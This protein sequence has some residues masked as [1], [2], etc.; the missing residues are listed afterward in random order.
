MNVMSVGVLENAVTAKVQKLK[1]AWKTSRGTTHRPWQ[2]R[3]VHYLLDCLYSSWASAQLPRASQASLPEERFFKR[4]RKAHHIS[5]TPVG[6]L[7]GRDKRRNSSNLRWT[8]WET[9]EGGALHHDS[10][11]PYLRGYRSSG[12]LLDLIGGQLVALAHNAVLNLIHHFQITRV[13]EPVAGAEGG[14]EGGRKKGRE[15]GREGGENISGWMLMLAL[16]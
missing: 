9:H 11:S 3:R 12:Q 6:Q 16:R 2:W 10:I 8:R 14:R 1:A 13:T 15:G 5:G 7:V 4:R